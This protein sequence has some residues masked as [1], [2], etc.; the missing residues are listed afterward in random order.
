M[1]KDELRKTSAGAAVVAWIDGEH[2]PA[3]SAKLVGNYAESVGV[4]CKPVFRV[5]VK[6]SAGN[7]YHCPIELIEIDIHGAS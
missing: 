1:T 5:D 7:T 3:I 6:D 2:L 4:D